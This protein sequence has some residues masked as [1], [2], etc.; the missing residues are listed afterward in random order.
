MRLAEYITDGSNVSMAV[1]M[2]G[3]RGKSLEE[4]QSRF[5][6]EPCV[7]LVILGDALE[8]MARGGLSWWRG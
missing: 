6:R 3:G 5:E 7:T 2:T 8:M 4:K 1:G